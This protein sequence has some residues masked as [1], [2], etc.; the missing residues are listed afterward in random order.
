MEQWAQKMREIPGR[1]TRRAWWGSVSRLAV[2]DY[3]VRPAVRD[4][5]R[6]SK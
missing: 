2:R 1:A 6:G 5:E 3:R 4:M